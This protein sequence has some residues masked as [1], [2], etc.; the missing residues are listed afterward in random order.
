MGGTDSTD[1]NLVD[2]C[3]TVHYIY[4]YV[5]LNAYALYLNKKDNKVPSV[6][7]YLIDGTIRN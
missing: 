3:L 2:V 4:A 6:R 5:N 1:I 7:L